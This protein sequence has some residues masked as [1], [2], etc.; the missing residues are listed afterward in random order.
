MP[1]RGKEINATTEA[2]RHGGGTEKKEGKKVVHE[3]HEGHE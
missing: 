1:E 2:R 3:E